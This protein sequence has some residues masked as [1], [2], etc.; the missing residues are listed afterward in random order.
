M[1]IIAKL[2]KFVI[3]QTRT[4]KSDYYTYNE[5]VGVSWSSDTPDIADVDENGVITAKKP[6]KAVIRVKTLD[7]GRVMK[8]MS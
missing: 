8:L 2:M 6:G 1:T 5:P 4:A 7:S 3:L